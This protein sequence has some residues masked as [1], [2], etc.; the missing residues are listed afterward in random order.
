VEERPW[1][2]PGA[3]RAEVSQ[4]YPSRVQSVGHSSSGAAKAP[5]AVGCRPLMNAVVKGE[6]H[7]MLQFVGAGMV[8]RAALKDEKSAW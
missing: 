5:A 4:L 1:T 8:A 7:K 6:N 2:L 3:A